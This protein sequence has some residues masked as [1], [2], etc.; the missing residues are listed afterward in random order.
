M[1]HKEPYSFINMKETAINKKEAK[2]R[3][4]ITKEK[5]N[6]KRSVISSPI[7]PSLQSSTTFYPLCRVLI[8]PLT[9]N[10]SSDSTLT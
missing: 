1:R 2:D 7:H 5:A 4:S 9:P 8:Y 3:I 10:K 6:V